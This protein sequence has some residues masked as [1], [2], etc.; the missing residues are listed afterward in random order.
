MSP[1]GIFRAS[2]SECV[3]APRE[4]ACA[5][6]GDLSTQG[7]SLSRHGIFRASSSAGV[8]A[9]RDLS[10]WS[11]LFFLVGCGSLKLH[12]GGTALFFWICE[13]YQPRSLEKKPSLSR[14]L[15]S[16][17]LHLRVCFSR[18]RARNPYAPWRG[19]RPF[20]WI[21]QSPE[22][23]TKT[24]TSSDPAVLWI[25]TLLGNIRRLKRRSQGD[26]SW[27][28]DLKS[29]RVD[30]ATHGGVTAFVRIHSTSADDGETF[31]QRSGDERRAR[32]EYTRCSQ[33]SA[34][35]ILST[36]VSRDSKKVV[37]TLKRSSLNSSEARMPHN[38]K[39][40]VK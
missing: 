14:N 3:S 20:F 1:H 25:L 18:A 39:R 17:K 32:G 30:P 8:F 33:R 35:L 13:P 5:T 37:M 15:W 38:S 40:P 24:T 27:H 7:R 23:S 11:P 12:G 6:K 28:Q 21:H 29:I 26:C 19:Y 22:P 9:P 34:T 16:L 10:H 2:S 4:R 36:S 31:C